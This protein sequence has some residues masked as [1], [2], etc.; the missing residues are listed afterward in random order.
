ML[1]NGKISAKNSTTRNF[2][3]TP[4]LYILN[5]HPGLLLPGIRSLEDLRHIEPKA[6]KV[7]RGYMD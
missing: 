2:S 3:L 5:N 1:N 6:R 4:K 7:Y